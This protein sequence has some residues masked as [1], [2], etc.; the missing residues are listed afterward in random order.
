MSQARRDG[1]EPGPGPEGK[2]GRI[3]VTVDFDPDT[4]PELHALVRAVAPGK[5]RAERIRSLMIK[6]HMVELMRSLPAIGVPRTVA[7]SPPSPGGAEDVF[8]DP[9]EG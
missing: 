2:G 1:E 7:A 6:G 9:L 5:Q 4:Y 8:G 3:T